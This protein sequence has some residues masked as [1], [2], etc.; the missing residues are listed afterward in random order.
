MKRVLVLLG[1]NLNLLG[2]REPNMYGHRTLEEIMAE[3]G[4]TA[5][6]LG[7]EVE[8]FQSNHEGVLVDRLHEVAQRYQGVL[9]NPGGL[10]H[11]SVALRDAV[12]ACGVPVILVHMSNTWAREA[13]R[14]EEVIGSGCR[15]GIVGLG[16]IGF[17]AGL[18]AFHRM[19]DGEE[20]KDKP[21]S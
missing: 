6:S 18:W 15:G 7:M 11:T 5:S 3:L 20:K 17:H 12:A 10:S 14:R 8:V 1:P 9:F 4:T 21:G 19:W 13:F 2:T 16:E